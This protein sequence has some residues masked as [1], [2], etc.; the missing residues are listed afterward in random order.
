MA[1]PRKFTKAEVVE[2]LTKAHG[3]K[4]GAAEL[5][6][7]TDE[8]IARYCN[9]FP[10]CQAVVDHWH[11]RRKDRAEYKL[12]EA[13]ERGEAWAVM[14]TLKNA[15]DREYNE[16]VI[17]AGDKDNPLT[18]QPFDYGTAVAPLAPRPGEDSAAPG[19]GQGDS[20]GPAVGQD[21]DG[22]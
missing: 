2:A 9:R 10:E 13:I 6:A 14:F 22:G 21:P 8:T 4:T 7:V 15:R 18:I 11:K 1:R 20:D 16:R 12:D 19:E 5:L 17:V 3:L